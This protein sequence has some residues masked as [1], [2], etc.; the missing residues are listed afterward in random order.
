MI[1]DKLVCYNLQFDEDYQGTFY[2]DLYTILF[3]KTEFDSLS[4]VSELAY[5]NSFSSESILDILE[6]KKSISNLQG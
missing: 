3:T 1:E 2:R 5:S 6:S 4:K